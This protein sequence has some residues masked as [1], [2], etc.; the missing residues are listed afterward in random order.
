[1]HAM[2]GTN[3]FGAA[4]GRLMPV[5]VWGLLACG[6]AWAGPLAIRAQEAAVKTTG[7][8]IAPAENAEGGWNL[9]NNG[10]LG[11]YVKFAAGGRYKIT[12]R[13]Y[14]SPAKGVW[15]LMEIDLDDLI[16]ATV[17][18]DKAAFT[19]YVFEANV[20]PGIRRLKVAFLNDAAVPDPN[21]PKR[22]IED[23][24]LYVN[25]V[26]IEPPAG[27]PAP[28]LGKAEDWARDAI[29]REEKTLA[30][31]EKQIERNRKADAAV[32]VV[33]AGGKP[34]AGAQVA[35][36]LARH[37][38]L[39]GCNIYMFDRFKTPADNEQYK[40]RFAELFN[41]ATVGFYWRGYETRRGQP[42]YA[43]TDKVVAWC[44]EQGIRM[45]GHPLLWG[46]EAGIPPWSK[47][48]PDANTQR[49]RVTNIL[50]RYGGKITFWEVVNEAAH[51]A[52]PRIDEPYRW[53]RQGDPNACLIVNDYQ[54]LADGCPPFL[55]LL[56]K[57]QADSVPFDGIGI[58][59]HEPRTM[60][61]PLD[62]VRAILDRYAA[63]GKDLYI[64][65]F[66]PASSGEA[67]VGSPA[68]GKWDEKAQEDYAVK[69][70]RVCFAHPAVKGITWWDLCDQ[71][72]WL[73][74]GGLLRKDLSPKPAYD[75]LRK[76]IHEEWRTQ[77]Q[78]PTDAAGQFAF[79]GFA[80]RYEVSV[81]AGGKTAKGRLDL[82][83]GPGGKP[84][85]CVV[86]V[87]P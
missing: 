83:G 61:F 34:V 85:T 18:V 5:L 59:A 87:A 63:L 48:Q 20:G 31:T 3:H 51:I 56:K 26:E 45:K 4:V 27:G 70:Y 54:V 80:G 79:R 38:F 28:A 62:R 46:H 68:G 64:T 32:R 57:A 30:D 24:N 65:E 82:R 14:G 22:W 58:Q 72:S 7:G 39:F 21:D 78:G 35:A 36:E 23:R 50:G 74:G 16:V 37:E 1:M 75:S 40:R 19:N 8:K 60:R 69:F 49:E 29:Q 52:E 42:G 84:V 53:A 71:G 76:L 9:W 55:A 15:P 6:P 41:F 33:D 86:T 66:T 81:T 67:V 13:A 25:R 44:L 10:E 11:D 2:R 77:A 17:T 43:Y 12:V 47:G 73:A